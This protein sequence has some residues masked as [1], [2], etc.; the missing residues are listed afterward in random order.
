MADESP[1]PEPL[2]VSVDER[3]TDEELTALALAADADAPVAEGAIP[4]WD[5]IDS[6]AAP[7]PLPGWYMPAP[8]GRTH[9]V[10]GWPRRAALLVII[11]FVAVNAAGLCSTYGII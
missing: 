5:V 6:G 4:L 10:T 1:S 11:A 3:F 7:S 2:S 8:M 9:L